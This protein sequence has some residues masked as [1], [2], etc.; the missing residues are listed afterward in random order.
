MNVTLLL[1]LAAGLLVGLGAALAVSAIGRG[2]PVLA[3]AL[4]ALDERTAGPSTP[5]GRAWLSLLRRLPGAVPAA[6]LELLGWTRDRFLLGRAGAAATYCAAGPALALVLAVVDV[7]LPIA[8]PAGFTLAGAV[9]GWS[10]YARRVEQRAEA[11][12]EELRFA[13]VSYLQQVSLLRRGG[14][15]VATA[16]ALPARLLDDG[17]AM[18]RIGEELDLAE[19]SGQMPWDGLRRFGERIDVSELADLSSIA[20]TAGHDGGAV[21]DTL[22]ARAESLHDELLADEHAD[23]HRASGQMSTPGAVQVFLISAWVLFPA[24]AALL[25]I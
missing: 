14:A 20:A 25:A 3:D 21:I 1:A 8:V 12:R 22:L 6:D 5:Q 11:A 17:W 10:G 16:L 2:H 23:A 13:L 4:A 18:R 19:R 7:G 9:V 15:G 24:G